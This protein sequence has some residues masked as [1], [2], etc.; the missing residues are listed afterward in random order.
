MASS[1][2]NQ[3]RRWNKI[4]IMWATNPRVHICPCLYRLLCGRRIFFLSLKIAVMSSLWGLLFIFSFYSLIQARN[5]AD[6]SHLRIPRQPHDPANKSV[7]QQHS[8]VRDLNRRAGRHAPL[9][10][11]NGASASSG[12]P[13]NTFGP[14]IPDITKCLACVGGD[15][16]IQK[17]AAAMTA[18]LTPG[19]L[20]SMM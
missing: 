20:K 12:N 11:G 17:T 19:Y 3:D 9:S 4:I 7:W 13:P 8:V 18:K 5:I 2:R 6:T 10:P 14:L 1:C 15:D 16:Q